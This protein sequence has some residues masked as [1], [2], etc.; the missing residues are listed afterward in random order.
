VARVADDAGAALRPMARAGDVLVVVTGGDQPIAGT[1][2]R[3]EAWGL[4]TIHL[5]VGRRPLDRTAGHVIWLSED[6]AARDDG[7][8]VL[9]F[10]VLWELT[11]ICFE[12]PGLLE[13]VD[14]EQEACV[15]CS[16]ERRLGEVVGS[17]DDDATIR[18]ASGIETVSTMLV[19]P[20]HP[21]DLVLVHA[22]TAISL[23][24]A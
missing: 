8:L 4:T 17:E 12:H 19:G 24:D 2:R 18:T 20:V 5:G 15:V 11:H 13:A 9:D 10:H 1:L 14:D 22:G 16:D 21:G 23:V 7:R 3:A 6:L